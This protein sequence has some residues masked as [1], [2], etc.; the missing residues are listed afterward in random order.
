MNRVNYKALYLDFLE[1][2]EGLL[3]IDIKMRLMNR[4]QCK[5]HEELSFKEL[6]DFNQIIR[7]HSIRPS[8]YN[9]YTSV[10][11][12]DEAYIRYVLSYQEEYKLSNTQVALEF[13][14]SRNTLARWQKIF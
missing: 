8:S 6:I 7:K 10:N 2:S 1:E 4:I 3:P 11:S 13:K 14:L 12:Y 5:L 9:T